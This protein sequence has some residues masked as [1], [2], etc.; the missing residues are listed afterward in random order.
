[1]K[2]EDQIFKLIEILRKDAGKKCT[3]DKLLNFVLIDSQK[4]KTLK[5]SAR[6]KIENE[7][8]HIIESRLVTNKS[9]P[10]YDPQLLVMALISLT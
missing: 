3:T 2:L 5:S 1:M 10:Y 6:E 8:I 9:K 4:S 7:D